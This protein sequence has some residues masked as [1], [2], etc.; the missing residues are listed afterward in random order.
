M[1]KN[2]SYKVY[3]PIPDIKNFV[4]TFVDNIYKDETYQKFLKK[5]ENSDDREKRKAQIIKK[6]F[7]DIK[8]FNSQTQPLVLARD[9][10]ILMGISHINTIIKKFDENE[11]VIGYIKL[12]NGKIKK[13]NFLTR[14]G[15]YRAFLTSRS[16]LSKVFRNFIYTLL[17]H[18]I[19]HETEK[20]KQII[21]QFQR[22]NPE[23]IKES[24]QEL[25]ENYIKYKKLYELENKEKL[26]WQNK[27][28]NINLEKL[29]I[30]RERD[31]LDIINLHNEAELYIIKN[32]KNEYLNNFKMLKSQLQITEYKD[33]TMEDELHLLKTKYLK[34]IQIYIVL[35]YFLNKIKDLP[36]ITNIINKEFVKD[37]LLYLNNN[38][39]EEINIDI[40]EILLFKISFGK[41]NNKVNNKFLY[42]TNDWL[43]D[44]NT[45]NKLV[46]QLK[47]DSDWFDIK[48][49]IIFKTSLKD[50]KMLI[51]TLLI[52]NKKNESVEY[53]ESSS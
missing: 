46:M 9:V 29:I 30:E 23:I 26:I 6:T 49:N 48:N 16:K 39:K 8:V 4:L 35:P 14:N 13:M 52:E 27:A 42:V 28:E 38:V 18:M 53:Y 20:L 37:Y 10:G 25:N 47:K 51:H 31:E 21:N 15:I 50:I 41:K 32:Q 40:D 11:K 3:E 43:Y 45:F 19:L 24:I 12:P 22:D 34:E 17:D 33:A 5:L 44:K 36:K 7:T 1:E 2:I